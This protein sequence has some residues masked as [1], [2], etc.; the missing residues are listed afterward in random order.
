MGRNHMARSSILEDLMVDIL[1]RSNQPLTLEE[2]TIKIRE[3]DS[4]LLCGATP[5]K[6]LYSV[7]FRRESR[8]SSMNE[9][10][11]FSKEKRGGATYYSINQNSMVN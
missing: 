4:T 10:L 6:S 11:I 1:K 8:R 2:I 3:V 9:P 5:T 7:L